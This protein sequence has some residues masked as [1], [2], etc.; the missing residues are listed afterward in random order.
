M[1]LLEPVDSIG[2]AECLLDSFDGSSR[3]TDVAMCTDV[4]R[5]TLRERGI[6]IRSLDNLKIMTLS[7]A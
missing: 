5:E 6:D 4:E 2:D 1:D 7:L 3:S